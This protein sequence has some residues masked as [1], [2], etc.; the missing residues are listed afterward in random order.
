MLIPVAALRTEERFRGGLNGKWPVSRHRLSHPLRPF[1]ARQGSFQCL[2]T[3]DASVSDSFRAKLR[4]R[5]YRYY[6]AI[7]GASVSGHFRSAVLLT[8]IGAFYGMSPAS[9]R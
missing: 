8:A 4:H 6:R 9:A 3:P 5:G 1:C 7:D 2:L